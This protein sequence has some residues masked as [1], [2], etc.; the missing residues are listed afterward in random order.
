MRR[1]L[2]VALVA[3]VAA[4]CSA[5]DGEQTAAPAVETVTVTTTTTEDE[6]NGGRNPPATG[7]GAEDDGFSRIP[8]IV[9]RV[10]PSVVAIRIAGGEGSGVIWD[11]EG[12][13]VTNNHVVAGAGD[14]VEI[15]LASG[16]RL[17]A[18]VQATDPRSDLAVLHVDRD[19]LPAARF[20]QELPEVGELAIAMGNPLGFE[21]SVTAG[22]V[23]GLHRSLPS[24]PETVLVELIQ[25]DAAISPGNSGGALVDANGEVI[26][27]NVA[28]VPPQGGAVALGF[29]I[30]ARTVRDIVGQL[31]TT[32]RVRHA[33]LGVSLQDVSPEIASELG[34][35]EGAV[36][37]E[38]E[39]GTPAEEAGIRPGDVIVEFEG[40]EIR[41]VEDFLTALR[42]RKP[43]DEV[44]IVVLRDGDRRSV[45]A[46]L[47]ERPPE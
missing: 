26:G 40:D 32:G 11:D 29:A 34:V 38:V 41:S 39:G 36:T 31:I 43:G 8:E 17:D 7:G 22:I 21:Q 24:S 16:E 10:E 1:L 33:Y 25:T 14:E 46:T 4:A 20:A 30:P 27:I 19:G 5:T 44:T 37:Y 13:I 15:A 9:D 47:S 28:Y 18:E 23:S 45:E 35:E 42:A 2:L 6:E 12:H 3:L